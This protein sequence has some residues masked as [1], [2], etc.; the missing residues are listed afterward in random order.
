[1]GTT[2][3]SYVLE[4][5]YAGIGLVLY[6]VMNY[7]LLVVLLFLYYHHDLM[8]KI[9]FQNCISICSNRS[10]EIIKNFEGRLGPSA[11]AL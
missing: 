2:K 8:V 3:A 7:M 1:M 11:H 5:L 10:K 4:S 6:L 9:H